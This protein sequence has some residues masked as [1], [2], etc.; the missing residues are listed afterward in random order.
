MNTPGLPR[1][2]RVLIVDDQPLIRYGVRE[3]LQDQE[4]LEWCG[5]ADSVHGALAELETSQP[6]LVI[7]DISLKDGGGFA[8]VEAVRDHHPSVA[9]LVWSM[10]DEKSFAES[11]LRAG[12]GGYVSKAAS[13]A[14]LVQTA[15]DILAG[16]AGAGTSSSATS[17]AR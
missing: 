15:L 1:P 17:D 10:Y 2:W 7:T 16:R 5:E 4:L 3:L 14:E 9:T 11:A 6:D 8:L 13:G 12:A